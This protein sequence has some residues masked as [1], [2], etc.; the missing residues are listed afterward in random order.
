MDTNT[1]TNAF[2]FRAG[3]FTSGELAVA[4]FGGAEELSRCYDINVELVARDDEP[5]DIDS[6]LAEE[7]VLT[8]HARG[9]EDRHIHGIVAA[10]WAEGREGGGGRWRYRA[11]LV[12]RL[13]LLNHRQDCRIFQEKSTVEIVTSIF[14][15]WKVEYR[16]DLQAS[17]P[18]R[19]FCVQYRESDFAFVA[20]L[21]ADEGIWWRF[22]HDKDKHVLVL[23][24]APKAYVE[25]PDDRIYYA[26]RGTIT[27]HPYIF[28]FE[29]D[30]SVQTA[31]VELSSYSFERPTLN[32]DAAHKADGDDSGLKEVEHVDYLSPKEGRRRAKLRLEEHRCRA[33]VGRGASVC[34]ELVPGATFE[35]ARHEVFPEFN[36]KWTV[37]SVEHKGKQPEALG[38]QDARQDLYENAFECIPNDVPWRPERCE[39]PDIPG[40]HTATVVGP[41]G[42]EI[43][44]DKYGRIKVHFHWDRQGKKNERSS[45]WVRLSHD[46]AGEGW[47][48]MYI[49]RIGMEVVVQFVDGDP[50]RP[51]IIGTL[52]N[53]DNPPPLTLPDE[54]TKTVL[55][56]RSTPN[57][58]GAN[59]IMFEDSAGQEQF[60]LHAERDLSIEVK[61]DK[62][63]IIGEHK[64]GT[65][66]GSET[67][68]VKKDR[69]KTVDGQQTMIVA[70]ND[71]IE[72][73][74]Q[75]TLIVIGNRTT[76]V[77]GDQSEVIARNSTE[78]VTLARRHEVKL[79]SA[80]TIALAKSLNIGGAYNIDVGAASVTIAA[81][82]YE[83]RVIGM[84]TEQVGAFRKET[85]AGDKTVHVGG[86]N[87]VEIGKDL[88]RV[89]AGDHSIEAH[90]SVRQ[91]VKGDAA[92][93][94]KKLEFKADK[95][96]ITAAGGKCGLVIENGTL[97][98][99]GQNITIDGSSGLKI[100]GNKIELLETA[101]ASEADIAARKKLAYEFYKAQ[102][103]KESAI[104]D[105]MAGIDFNKRVDVRTLREGK[106]LAQYQAPGA[107]QGNYY[108][109]LGTKPE[110]LGIN[111]RGE[112]RDAAGKAIEKVDKVQNT[113]EVA[114]DTQALRST[115]APMKDT[116]SIR[117]EP[118]D[119][120]GGGAQYFTTSKTSIV[121]R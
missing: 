14:D 98:L 86:D 27:S 5:L 55:R 114:K 4:A 107:P 29:L 83:T 99:W 65:P 112:I 25:L 57:G 33:K 54:N 3:S 47:G 1:N 87:V 60:S 23:G 71:S 35:I 17:Y 63:Q 95:L 10:V 26:E 93:V 15:A 67:L 96:K 102:G 64:N 91:H 94:A 92:L 68:T 81:T 73:G 37:V 119:A 28:H 76:E 61:N 7:A 51:I 41:K 120:P 36:R 66:V 32:L 111:P 30:L 70:Q 16:N 77:H 58:D 44:T 38:T 34:P 103:F 97:K 118:F 52:Y 108:A 85:V 50:D 117:G 101:P 116:W 6:C 104:E 106:S 89:V 20:R 49:P 42:E 8:I 105:H 43:Y 78:F 2:S 88:Q 31:A 21:L 22:E 90:D 53:G 100:T 69:T 74:G 75:Q 121:L 110:T 24:D 72:I 59:E 113:Y 82:D 80:E 56:T 79:A 9:G 115:A 39:R 13:W 109:E 48:A 46:W 40:V 12:P 45:C 18:T 84:S 62:T 11:Q 19:S